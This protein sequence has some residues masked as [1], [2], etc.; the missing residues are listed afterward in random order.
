MKS[1]LESEHIKEEKYHSDKSS[2]TS[3]PPL[4]SQHKTEEER[5]NQ[6]TDS[7]IT[8]LR[9][10][11]KPILCFVNPQIHRDNKSVCCFRSSLLL[12]FLTEVE[13]KIL[14]FSQLNFLVEVHFGQVAGARYI[15]KKEK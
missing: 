1:S 2:S 9:D 4:P 8:A 12:S 7:L 5:D 10:P 13:L 6:L 11:A 3:L 14:E 15:F